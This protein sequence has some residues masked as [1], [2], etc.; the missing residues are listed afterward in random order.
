MIGRMIAGRYKVTEALGV[1]GMAETYIAI[2]T[3]FP[4]EPL[5]GEASAACQ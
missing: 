1:G 3:Q 5:C 2:D 4:N